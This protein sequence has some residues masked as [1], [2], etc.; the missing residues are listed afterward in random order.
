MEILQR[1]KEQVSSEKEDLSARLLQLQQTQA[2]G[3][4]LHSS[5]ALSVSHLFPVCEECVQQAVM[6]ASEALQAELDE[7]KTKYQGLLRDFTRLEQ[8]YDNL[9]EMSL[10][11]EVLPRRPSRE[12]SNTTTSNFA[13]CPSPQTADSE[14]PQK[15]RLHPE[16]KPGAPFTILTS[17]VTFPTCSPLPRGSAQG[18]RD[19]SWSREEVFG[20]EL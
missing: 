5:V 10:L 14:G 3:S 12:P 7:E 1:E 13:S 4:E 17:A 18:Q 19:V 9:K 20:V 2:G 16:S 6:K 15:E 8:R 11:P